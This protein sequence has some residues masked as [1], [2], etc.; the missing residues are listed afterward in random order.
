MNNVE[1]ECFLETA[2]QHSFAKA[3]EALNFTPQA[4][5]KN[6]STLERELNTTLFLRKKRSVEMTE[7]GEYYFS[8]FSSATASLNRILSEVRNQEEIKKN[9]LRLGLSDWLS[10]AGPVIDGIKS[11]RAIHHALRV[12]TVSLPAQE[13]IERVQSNQM[14][15]AFLPAAQFTET[16]EI[17][18]VAVCQN[19]YNLLVPTSRIPQEP[20]EEE[21]LH[22]F[23]LPLLLPG[24]CG[25]SFGERS[26]VR[27]EL[28][29]G[30]GKLYPTSC[31]P[32]QNR[33][34]L[35]LELMFPRYA[36]V[37]EDGIY[38]GSRTD[39]SYRSFPLGADSQLLCIWSV[40]NN[41]EFLQTIVGE[42]CDFFSQEGATQQKK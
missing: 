16:R 11:L 14:D 20:T 1:I 33:N 18:A 5:S 29:Q 21:I 7:A 19:H 6:V 31:I 22:C 17:H 15:L 35:E 34:T 32:C 36:A 40:A 10:P 23:G 4:V 30:E 27:V 39:R 3:G 37:V 28:C 26:G 13:L 25:Q 42:L 41:S 24:Y 9:F 8:L 2:Y 38:Y 12:D